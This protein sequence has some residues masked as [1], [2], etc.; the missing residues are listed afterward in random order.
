MLIRPWYSNDIITCA[1]IARQ[2]SD[3]QAWNQAAYEQSF[4]AGDW[5]WLAGN[6]YEHF[7]CLIARPGVDSVDLLD[8]QV[9]PA[10][11]RQGVASAL[12]THLLQCCQRQA[13]PQVFIE[14][15]K[16]NQ[17]AI[18]L[19]RGYGFAHVG[20]RQSYYQALG[21]HGA[22]AALVMAWQ[23]GLHDIN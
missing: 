20:E 3:V 1:T 6:E 9:I 18:E 22:E 2:A 15:R 14:V 10:R 21:A 7:G 4:I 19:Y 11:Q 12:I 5:G 8:L 17:A 13:R 23:P 16:S